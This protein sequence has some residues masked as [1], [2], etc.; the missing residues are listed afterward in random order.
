[1]QEEKE[2]D[3]KR[4]KEIQK[5]SARIQA[6]MDSMADVVVHKDHDL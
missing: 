2:R 1:M 4:E 6:V 5:R 3:L